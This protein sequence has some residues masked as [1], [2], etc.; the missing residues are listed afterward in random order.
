M[1]KRITGRICL[2]LLLLYGFVAVIFGFTVLQEW[3]SES[4]GLVL[5][6]LLFLPG[7]VVMMSSALWL[8]ACQRHRYTLP[9]WIGGLTSLCSA[10]IF[11]WVTLTEVLPCSGPA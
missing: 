4:A 6:G 5:F 3:S 8:L 10:G 7:G 1:L 11:A 9:L 2:A